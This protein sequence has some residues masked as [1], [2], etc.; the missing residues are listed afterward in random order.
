MQNIE[1]ALGFLD[2]HGRAVDK[3]WARATAGQDSRQAV[4]DALAAYQ[5]DDGGFG[6]NLEVDIKAP[7]SQPFATG[8]AMIVLVSLGVS[9]D[10]PIVRFAEQWL[11]RTQHEDGCWRFT[12]G[13]YDHELAPWFAGWTFPSLNP[14]LC[15][16][17]AAKRLR[18]GSDRL[19][20][21]VA[22]LADRLASLEEV[23]KGE[24][25]SIL[26]YVE[27]FPWVDH[28]RR[29]EF[30]DLV[31][32]RIRRTAEAGGYD[33]A[34]HFFGHAGPK[35]GEIARRLSSD[36]LSSQLTRLRGE[37]QDDGGWPS[38]YDPAWRSWATASAVAILTDF[39]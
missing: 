9:P 15:L 21:R 30:L 6:R 16:A 4:I 14:A 38:P 33:D 35:D 18:I 29:T 12:S 5:N 39:A 22:A 17:G 8:L 26:P 28:P 37:Q 19:F 34:G 1:R 10:E 23:E 11:E 25:C 3:V 36:L 31:A 7:D 27:Y 20:A 13:V 24:F 32:D 2:M